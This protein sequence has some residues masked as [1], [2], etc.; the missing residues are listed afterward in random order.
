MG[1]EAGLDENIWPSDCE[2]DREDEMNKRIFRRNYRL[3]PG[4]ASTTSS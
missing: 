4:V 2:S 3:E 1:S